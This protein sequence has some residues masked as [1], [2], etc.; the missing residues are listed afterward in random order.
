MRRTDMG[1][2]EREER[3]LAGLSKALRQAQFDAR[4]ALARFQAACEGWDIPRP[5]DLMDLLGGY[6]RAHRLC[7]DIGREVLLQEEAV[8]AMLGGADC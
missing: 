2:L 8:A 1:A 7:E 5:E 4:V 6:T 3:K